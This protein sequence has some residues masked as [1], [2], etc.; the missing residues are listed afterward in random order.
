MNVKVILFG[1]VF[2]VL[3]TTSSVFSMED[4]LGARMGQL[5]AL[6]G[7]QYDDP[8]KIEGFIDDY[9]QW[10]RDCDNFVGREREQMIKRLFNGGE[11][12]SKH[13]YGALRHGDGREQR[14]RERYLDF[15]CRLIDDLWKLMEIFNAPFPKQRCV[16][17]AARVRNWSTIVRDNLKSNAKDK[18]ALQLAKVLTFIPE[19]RDE[20]DDSWAQDI[21]TAL[22]NLT[23]WWPERATRHFDAQANLGQAARVL[24]EPWN[25]F[26]EQV[27]LELS[28][29]VEFWTVGDG[30]SKIDRTHQSIE[31]ALNRGD[32]EDDLINA[33]DKKAG[34]FVFQLRDIRENLR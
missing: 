21:L 19:I 17:L 23:S 7:Q 18:A 26:T 25:Q 9:E 11:S 4:A 32:A 29:T 6:N 28:N 30:F 34:D 3:A 22:T 14:P 15:A 8:N 20:H 27:L 24:V 16:E 12:L 2:S 1:M 33:L 13:V 10:M 31:Q 5:A